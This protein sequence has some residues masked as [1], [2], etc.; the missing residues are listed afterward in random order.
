MFLHTS[1]NVDALILFLDEAPRP[2]R[3]Q[4]DGVVVYASVV[5]F[6]AL[7]SFFTDLITPVVYHAAMIILA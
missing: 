1:V 2:H 7:A 5:V 3:G 4:L 6:C